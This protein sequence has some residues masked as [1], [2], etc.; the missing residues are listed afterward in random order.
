MSSD[1]PSAETPL[2]RELRHQETGNGATQW[3]WLSHAAPLRVEA[4]VDA[5]VKEQ[6]EYA[7]E[8]IRGSVQSAAKGN[9]S[10][11]EHFDNGKHFIR[12]AIMRALACLPRGLSPDVASP[13]G[14]RVSQ[15]K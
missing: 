1:S 3:D 10:L 11:Y 5:I 7:W 9:W 2:P 6:A 14:V 4:S 12:E 8:E 13:S 15:T